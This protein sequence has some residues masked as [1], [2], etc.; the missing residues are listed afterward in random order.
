MARFNGAKQG[1]AVWLWAVVI[2]A[3]VAVL[4]YVAGSKYDVLAK[5]NLPR[6][7]VNEGTLSKGGIIATIALAVVSL[8]AALLGGKFG[9]H[10]HRKVDKAGLDR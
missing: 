7:P 4:A 5:L 10:F 1:L 8:V 9:M 6:I 2:A 3:A